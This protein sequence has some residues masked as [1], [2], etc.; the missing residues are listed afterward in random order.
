MS[1]LVLQLS[2]VYK[3]GLPYASCVGYIVV[4]CQIWRVVLLSY[5][6]HYASSVFLLFVTMI[7]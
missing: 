1:R 5:R 2:F 7:K 6:S 4:I 3:G